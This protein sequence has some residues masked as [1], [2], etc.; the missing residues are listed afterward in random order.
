MKIANDTL[1]NTTFAVGTTAV[2]I[3]INNFINGNS[4]A[5]QYGDITRNASYVNPYGTGANDITDDIASY[6]SN[7]SS[8]RIGQEMAGATANS[9]PS[10]CDKVAVDYGNSNTQITTYYQPRN[11]A[12]PG[13][14]KN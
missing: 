6:L 3:G 11:G 14:E 1:R 8:N 5:Y 9:M 2:G 10:G 13:T 4:S 7:E 12:I